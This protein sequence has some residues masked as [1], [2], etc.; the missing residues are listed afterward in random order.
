MKRHTNTRSRV[1]IGAVAMLCALALMGSGAS[2]ADAAGPAIVES[3]SQ[4]VQITTARLHARINPGG[5][6][7]TYHFDYI[8]KSDFD[9]NLS[10]AKEGFDGSLRIPPVNEASIGDGATPVKVLQQL[11]ALSGDTTYLYRVVAQNSAGTEVGPALSMKTREIISGTDTCPNRDA[12]EQ[13]RGRTLPDCRGYEMVSPVDKN[14]GQIDAPGAIAGGGVLQAAANGQAIT[15]GSTASFGSGA[16]GAAPASQYIGARGTQ[17]WSTLNITAPIFSGTFADGEGVPYR[18]FS[19][20]LSRGLL[21]NGDHCRGSATG[22]AI[23][24][25]PLAGTDAPVG[26]QNYYVRHSSGAFEALLGSADITTLKLGPDEFDLD[27]AGVNSNLQQVVVSTC[28]ALTSDATEVA[29]GG[30]CDP[31]KANL[32]RWTPAGLTLVNILPAQAQGTPGAAVGAQTGAISNDGARVY[33]TDLATSNLYLRDGA[34]TKQ[35]DT[36]AGGGAAFQTASDDGS[37]A[38]FT[39]ANHLYRYGTATSSATDLTPGGGVQGVLGAS[40]DGAYVYYLTG[41]GLFVHHAGSATEVAGSADP[42]NYPPTTGTARVSADGSHLV[43]TATD[44]LTGYDNLD[45]ETS[46]PTSQVYLYDAIADSLACVSCNPT[47]GRPLGP[48]SIP[49]ASVNGTGPSATVVYKPRVMT[50][51][52]RRVF[53]ESGDALG[54]LDTNLDVDVYQWEA[55]GTGSC[56][57]PEGCVSLISTG[58]D[59]GVTFIDASADGDDVFFLTAAS[60]VLSDPGGIDLYDARV[61]G[62]FPVSPP[63]LACDGDACQPLPPSPVDPTLTTRL[64]GPGN[65]GV[66]YEKRC[67]KGTVK[68]NGRCVKKKQ[69]GKTTRR[70]ATRQGAGR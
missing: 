70:N 59:K 22:C 38:Y 6:S 20:D 26:Y 69:R 61:E 23:A 10:A 19:G 15:Y 52:G 44:S 25:P 54:G 36:I 47:N 57:R 14:G 17:G 46:S 21:L 33:W 8:K 1:G 35:I 27:I 40:A 34:T 29:L 28:A 7:S 32:Y 2:S 43:F 48:S 30:S 42:V 37:I 65:P 16:L 5:L 58:K 12:R 50:M 3:W 11:G 39:K 9:A 51:D 64:S 68:R 66:R 67:K 63:P 55:D 45:Q 31:T 41:A 53:F 62:G 56:T 24:N 4:S 49:G 60:P 18:V 13:G